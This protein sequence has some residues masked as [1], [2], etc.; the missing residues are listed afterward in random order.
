MLPALYQLVSEFREAEQRLTDLELDEQTLA[1]TL[2]GLRFPIEQKATNVAA[3]ARNLEAA[4]ASIKEAEAAMAA[5]RKAIENRANRLRDYLKRNMEASGIS[6]IDSPYFSI[7]IRQNPPAVVIDAASQIPEEF[8]RIP[9]PPPPAPDKKAIAEAIKSGRE[10]AG[11]HL[12]RST[13]VEI[14]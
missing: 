3:V 14:K 10:V 13:R 8:M 9:E 6:K 11:C 5:R 4:A 2:E 12:E 1:D 7:A